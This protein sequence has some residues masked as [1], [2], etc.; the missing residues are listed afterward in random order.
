[1]KENRK[2]KVMPFFGTYGTMPSRVFGHFF[3]MKS[4][5]ILFRGFHLKFLVFA[6]VSPPLVKIRPSVS[7]GRFIFSMASIFF[8]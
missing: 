7:Y 3:A 6:Y 8:P 1:M 5:V 4:T 2:Y